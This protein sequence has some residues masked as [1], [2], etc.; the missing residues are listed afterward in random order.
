MVAMADLN[1]TFRSLAHVIGCMGLA[2]GVEY[3]RLGLW[4]F[5]VPLA[6][7]VVVLIISWVRKLMSSFSNLFFSEAL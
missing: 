1:V 7:A 5:I 4:V 2:I 3:D 6:I